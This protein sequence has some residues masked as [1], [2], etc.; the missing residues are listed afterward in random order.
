MWSRMSTLL[1]TLMQNSNNIAIIHCKQAG[2]VEELLATWVPNMGK[3][4]KLNKKRGYSNRVI[5]AV[6]AQ[7]VTAFS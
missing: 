7:V 2:D 4:I 6:K 3:V 1:R 5:K